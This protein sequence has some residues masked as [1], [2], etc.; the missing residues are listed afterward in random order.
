MRKLTITAVA[1]VLAVAVA[2]ASAK[3]WTKV[4]IGTEGAYPPFNYIDSNGKVQGFEIDLANA[5]CEK[6]AVECEYVVQDW[7]GIIPGL[8]AK[9]YDVIIASLY[10]T[11]ERK[12]K[13]DFTQR[14][15]KTPGRFVVK[16]GTTLDISEAGLKGKVIG[17]Q[18]ATAFER[19]LRDTYPGLDLRVY[20]TQDEVNMDLVAGRLDAQMADVVACTIAAS[21]SSGS[22]A[23]SRSRAAT[24]D[25]G[26]SSGDVAVEGAFDDVGIGV[27]S[28]SIQASLTPAASGTY[29]FGASSGSISI[30]LGRGG[31]RAYDVTAASD[32]E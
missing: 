1:A 2:G 8:L 30:D 29:D 3:E 25:V 6:M 5:L 19:F 9:K 22:I 12:E 28:G 11:D 31:G 21:S 24:L 14:Y 17:V 13:I 26:A 20:A 23:I 16:K 18:R 7:D 32:P 10:I 27:S 4:R 15:Y